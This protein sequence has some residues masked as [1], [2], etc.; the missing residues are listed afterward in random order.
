M[1]ISSDIY[2]KCL[3]P[4]ASGLAKVGHITAKL[5][6]EL[7]LMLWVVLGLGFGQSFLATF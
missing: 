3:G 5:N 4:W 2:L 1:T 6:P 7:K